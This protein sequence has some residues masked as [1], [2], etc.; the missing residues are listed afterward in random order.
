MDCM[1]LSDHDSTHKR[2]VLTSSPKLEYV[3]FSLSSLHSVEPSVCLVDILVFIISVT[4]V[5]VVK[6]E[7]TD[8]F[9]VVNFLVLPI[10]IISMVSLPLI[11]GFFLHCLNLRIMIEH[12]K[13]GI[14]PMFVFYNNIMN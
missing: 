1:E 12:L 4:F 13:L 5:F 2:F 14:K 9:F 3:D 7:E 8:D 10:N 11:D 6:P